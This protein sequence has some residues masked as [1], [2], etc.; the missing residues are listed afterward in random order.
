MTHKQDPYGWSETHQ[1]PTKRTSAL[2]LYAELTKEKDKKKL[3]GIVQRIHHPALRKVM[4][5]GLEAES[6]G[7]GAAEA[8]RG[9]LRESVKKS[10]RKSSF[11]THP[12]DQARKADLEAFAEKDGTPIP[13]VI[14]VKMLDIGV[15]GKID[16][17]RT[18]RQTHGIGHRY[19]T[20]PPIRQVILAYP[21]SKTGT[22]DL[23]KPCTASVRQSLAIVPE[24]L[25]IFKA[26]P[27]RL[28]S[29]DILGVKRNSGGGWRKLV[30]TYLRDCGFHSYAMVTPGCVLCYSDGA[31]L[32]LR[33]FDK[34]E[35]F[36]KSILRGVIGVR[37]TPFVDRMIPLKK[38]T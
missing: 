11:S 38:L 2:S 35:G 19:M 28:K 12:G 21:V 29:G 15:R 5:A 1:L 6:P 9:W 22:P 24:G 32:F 34:S 20:Q 13:A 30:E 27:E 36:K 10:I 33:N 7:A 8:L 16:L 23:V 18:D 31:T 14:G 3:A 25:A 26:L 37:R 4:G 17:Q